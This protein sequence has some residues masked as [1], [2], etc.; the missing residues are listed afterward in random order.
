MRLPRIRFFHV[1]FLRES[2]Y[3]R[4][5]PNFIISERNRFFPTLGSVLWEFRIK[6]IIKIKKIL[7]PTVATA[8]FSICSQRITPFLINIENSVIQITNFTGPPICTLN[9]ME[10]GDGLGQNILVILPKQTK[11]LLLYRSNARY[12]TPSYK[13][14]STGY[15]LSAASVDFYKLHAEVALNVDGKY[16]SITAD[17]AIPEKSKRN[18][19]RLPRWQQN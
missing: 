17:G 9:D 14:S 15:F 10:Q 11:T 19:T 5:F 8:H 4:G 13:S 1:D 2:W 12:Y 16:V 18:L 6:Y 3:F 7:F